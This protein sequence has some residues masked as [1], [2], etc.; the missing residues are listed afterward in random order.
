MFF[1][2]LLILLFLLTCFSVSAVAQM[3]TV[4]EPRQ[5]MGPSR[6]AVF[7]GVAFSDM[8]LRTDPGTVNPDYTWNRE[9][10]TVSAEISGLE[11][12]AAFANNITPTFPSDNDINYLHVGLRFTGGVPITGGRRAGVS[13]PVRIGTEFIRTSLNV[14][15][16]PQADEFRQNSLSVGAGAQAYLNPIN[17][18][19]MSVLLIP[20]IGFSYNAY[21][22]DSS[23]F[24]LVNAR[25]R[26]HLDQLIGR[27][28]LSLGYDYS[29]RRYSGGGARSDYDIVSHSAVFGINF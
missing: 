20:E 2:N 9:V 28:G 19:R 25:Y 15:N 14:A 5:R 29:F 13:V 7:A 27:F 16:Q 3:F 23:T 6:T 1:K 11:A 10:Y 17:R 12:F 4:E 24:G 21:G 26:L 18:V 8:N 22:S